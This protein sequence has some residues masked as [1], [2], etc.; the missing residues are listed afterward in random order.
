MEWDLET[1][2]TSWQRNC[3]HSHVCFEQ[4]TCREFVSKAD[5]AYA[6][7]QEYHLAIATSGQEGIEHRPKRGLFQLPKETENG[8]S[9]GL[10]TDIVHVL[11][12]HLC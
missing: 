9:L 1:K 12:I 5:F 4:V 8:T 3:I 10:I 2:I 11:G 7:E 6:R